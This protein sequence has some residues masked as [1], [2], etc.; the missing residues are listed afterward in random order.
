MTKG[1]AVLLLLAAGSA[2]AQ[3][4]FNVEGR[5]GEAIIATGQD[6]KWMYDGRYHFSPAYR[7]G[8]WVYFSGV[9]AGAQSDTP[10]GKEEFKAALHRAF[11]SLGATL[12]A[13]G[14]SFDDV[15]KI[16]SF[17]VFD[18]PFITLGKRE[19]VEAMAEVKGEYIGEPHPAWTAVGTTALLPDRGLVEIEIVAYA[20][21]E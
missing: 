3:E 1:I 19:Q 4:S 7:A 6:K 11:E 21:Q 17:H 2:Q 15:V 12:A 16:R 18:S 14:A 10:M 20:P 13:A 8:D 5:N 9:V